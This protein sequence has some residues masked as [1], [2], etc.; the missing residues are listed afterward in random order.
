MQKAI[1]E[2]MKNEKKLPLA[3]ALFALNLSAAFCGVHRTRKE[4]GNV[5]SK[6][7]DSRKCVF[8]QIFST[9]EKQF[10]ATLSIL[11]HERQTPQN[12]RNQEMAA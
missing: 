5:E 4:M 12:W 7:M 1:E 10:Y 3:A 8:R 6:L 11:V 9:E 2:A